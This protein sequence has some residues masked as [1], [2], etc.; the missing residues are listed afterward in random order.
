MKVT[1]DVRVVTEEDP[2]Y[3][4]KLFQQ[5]EAIAAILRKAQSA[6][7]ENNVSQVDSAHTIEDSS[8]DHDC[9]EEAQS[10]GLNQCDSQSMKDYLTPN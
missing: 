6:M 7:K 1:I 3:K 9:T 8:E 5:A 10:K 2:S 4:N